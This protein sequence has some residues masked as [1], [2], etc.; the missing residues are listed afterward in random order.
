MKV[1][2]FRRGGWSIPTAIIVCDDYEETELNGLKISIDNE[3]FHVSYDICDSFDEYQF[4]ELTEDTKI[5]SEFCSDLNNM[6]R[7]IDENVRM[8]NDI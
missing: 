4:D 1:L 5:L 7:K 8:K 6:F 2:K 3:T